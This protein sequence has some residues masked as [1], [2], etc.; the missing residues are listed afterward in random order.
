MTL[1]EYNEK[2]EKRLSINL[3]HLENGVEFIDIDNAYIDEE[4][5]IGSGT[6]IGPCTIIKGE[7]VIGKDC[8]ITQNSRIENSNIGDRVNID[9]SVIIDSSIGDETKVGPFAYLRPNSK[10]G[11]NCRIGDF[12]EVKNSSIGDGSKASHLTYIGD[13]DVGCDVNI[14]CGVV[15]VNYDGTNKQRSTIE[16]GAFIGCNTNLIAPVTVGES[17]YIAAGTTV[18]RNVPSDALCIGR[19]KERN[20]EGWAREKGLY[21]KK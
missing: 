5:T 20:L 16:D 21:K 6:L 17:A 19:T 11:K 12:V 2:K 8:I 18:S 9:S 7:T 13:G 1:K 4:V 3:K 10:I 14:G 15:F